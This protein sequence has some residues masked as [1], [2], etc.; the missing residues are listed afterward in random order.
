M[1]ASGVIKPVDTNVWFEAQND[2]ICAFCRVT[3]MALLRHLTMGEYEVTQGQYLAV[4]GSKP[5]RFLTTDQDS[6]FLNPNDPHT[7]S[8]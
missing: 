2:A 1:P 8:H 4:M 7:A 6:R 3:Q 5:S